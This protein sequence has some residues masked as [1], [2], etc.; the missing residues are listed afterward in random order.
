MQ[1][2]GA[3]SGWGTEIESSSLGSAR[4]GRVRANLG[5][6]IIKFS[7]SHGRRQAPTARRQLAAGRLRRR[8][9]HSNI[10]CSY[11][12][13]GLPPSQRFPIKPASNWM[14]S[15]EG[16]EI[17]SDDR[18]PG[19]RTRS[20]AALTRAR[21]RSRLQIWRRLGATT[22][23]RP[24]TSGSGRQVGAGRAA[25]GPPLGPADVSAD[26]PS[27]RDGQ[28]LHFRPAP[29][30]GKWATCNGARSGRP[31]GDPNSLGDL[32]HDFGRTGL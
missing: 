10:I 23:R 20:L 15:L 22:K 1:V 31:N 14:R 18:R 13:P 29:P 11:F 24:A 7:P 3:V 27:G 5:A 26:Q 32:G 2:A 25:N 6:V 28:N 9:K 21:V 12:L 19:G 8:K 17:R 30:A 4:S 16:H